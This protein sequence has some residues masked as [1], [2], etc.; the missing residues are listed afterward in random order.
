MKYIQITVIS[1]LLLIRAATYTSLNNLLFLL[2]AYQPY[3]YTML[4]IY[5]EV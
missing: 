4:Q 2:K 5:T 1:C 3:L